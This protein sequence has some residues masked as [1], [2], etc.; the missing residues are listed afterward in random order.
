MKTIWHKVNVQK[1]I[2]FLHT[3]NEQMEFEL[4]K[5]HLQ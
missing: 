3:S 5:Y 4:F 2:A 1:S